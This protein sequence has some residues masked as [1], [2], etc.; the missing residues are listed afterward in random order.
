MTTEENKPP[1][2][3]FVKFILNKTCPVC[4]DMLQIRIRMIADVPEEYEM[5]S[6]YNECEYENILTYKEKGRRRGH[7]KHKKRSTD[8]GGD[9]GVGW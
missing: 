9:E 1:L 2:G 8:E 7:G 6:S 4:G 3:R 5:C